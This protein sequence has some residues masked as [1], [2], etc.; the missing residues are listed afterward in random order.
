MDIELK[1]KTLEENIETLKIKLESSE[2]VKQGEIG[3][4]QALKVTIQKQQ[5]Y[6]NDLVILNE[7][8]IGQIAKAKGDLQF[9]LERK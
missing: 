1:I 6:I 7:K 4:N 8:Y 5:T 2:A 9:F 3:M